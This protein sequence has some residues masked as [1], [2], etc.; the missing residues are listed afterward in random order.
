MKEFHFATTM[1]SEDLYAYR[2]GR[3]VLEGEAAIKEWVERKFAAKGIDVSAKRTLVEEVI[4]G[5]KRRTPVRR[6][7]LNPRGKLD[8]RNGILDLQTF[9]LAPHNPN[10]EIFTVQL[11]VIFDDD[12][13]CPLFS[14]FL[15]ETQPKP[16]DREVLQMLAGYCLERG[17]PYQV[18][19]AM[20]GDGL[21][22]K[23]T[24]LG[25]LREML[26]PENVSAIKLQ[27]MD[28]NR[29]ATSE[30]VDKL[31]NIVAD[32]PAQAIRDT[33][34]F[35]MATG[36]DNLPAE[37]KYGRP[38][39]FVNDAKLIFSMNA[40]PKVDNKES[41]AFWRRWVLMEWSVRIPDPD[42]ELPA[43]LRKELDG[44]FMWALEGLRK[45]RAHHG[46]PKTDNVDRAMETWRQ[47][48]DTVYWFS[49]EAVCEDAKAEPV[50]KDAFY[51][52]Y[53]AFCE[54]KGV[55]PDRKA[56]LFKKLPTHL[57]S[58]RTRHREIG[59]MQVW[60]VAGVALE[61]DWAVEDRRIEEAK[62]EALRQAKLGEDDGAPTGPT[63]PTG[64]LSPSHTP[65]H[66]K[67]GEGQPVG[68][69]GPVGKDLEIVGPQQPQTPCEKCFK[70]P[71][72]RV[73]IPGETFLKPL[74]A[75]H[76]REL[77]LEPPE[78]S[79]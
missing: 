12:A 43:K 42:P 3:Y 35:R 14:R 66:A 55:V 11:P 45:L 8:I 29:F 34:N 76:L 16:E 39:H 7:T 65:A 59:G 15:E 69:V 30:M 57:P 68:T 51:E 60:C 56:D 27:A 2:D 61:P 54:S 77:G 64:S 5:V 75:S 1:D 13:A 31:A 24:F 32:L 70:P 4:A 33:G 44:V 9:R 25:V 48:S 40:F 79:A 28:T 74:C 67:T 46:F 63:T 22:G 20:Y 10:P 72:W 19:F 23:S 71:S 37:R 36:G 52:A 38:F 21:N 26:G 41:Y 73:S 50:S 17:N 78:G 49:T 58:V 62:A 47:R 18:A 6:E 53:V